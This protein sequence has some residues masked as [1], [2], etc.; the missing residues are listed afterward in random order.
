MK[1]K[2]WINFLIVLILVLLALALGHLARLYLG[3]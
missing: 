1:T 2:F 3:V